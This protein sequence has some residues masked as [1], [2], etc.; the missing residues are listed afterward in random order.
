MAMNVGDHI[1][2]TSEYVVTECGVTLPVSQARL[3]EAVSLA[4]AAFYS[5]LAELFPEATRDGMTPEGRD[6]FM[7]AAAKAAREWVESN[8]DFDPDFDFG[9]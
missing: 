9:S 7:R 6:G 4:E 1:R 3:A 5:A 8:V 2:R